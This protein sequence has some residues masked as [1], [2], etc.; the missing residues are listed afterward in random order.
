[1]VEEARL[2]RSRSQNL[3]PGSVHSARASMQ[4]KA[5]RGAGLDTNHTEPLE[6][7]R[8]LTELPSGRN[9]KTRGIGARC[10]LAQPRPRSPSNLGDARRRGR[11]G[12]T[13]LEGE[14]RTRILPGCLPSPTRA[15]S[16]GR[17]P[18][19][20]PE[21]DNAEARPRNPRACQ[22]RNPNR[23]WPAEREGAA[24]LVP[25][26]ARWSR[27]F[28]SSSSRRLAWQGGKRSGRAMPEQI[29]PV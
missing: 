12:G 25:W 22:L 26:R 11:K 17:R 15:E 20:W 28:P 13:G 27:S 24:A 4:A 7:P 10:P 3:R 2:R 18:G 1:M 23:P 9:Q 21:S 8:H 16:W 14:R 5:A 29:R 6:L 19:C